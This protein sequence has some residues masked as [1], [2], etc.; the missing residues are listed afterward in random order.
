M[1]TPYIQI[2]PSSNR[3]T[4]HIHLVIS[5]DVLGNSAVFLLAPSQTR[6]ERIQMRAGPTSLD[7]K[8]KKTEEDGAKDGKTP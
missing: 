2:Q 4:G 5:D 8:E 7:R 6:L 3:E 1:C